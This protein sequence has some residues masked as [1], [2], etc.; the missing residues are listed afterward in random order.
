[1]S[2]V[3]S[4]YWINFV[5][6]AV[7]GKLAEADGIMRSFGA[8][9]RS[10]ADKLETVMPIDSRKPI[11]RG[12][13]LDPTKPYRTDPKLMFLSWSEDPL[14]ARWFASPDS[15]ISVPVAKRHPNYRGYMFALEAPRS[16]VLFHYS[17]VKPDVFAAF[18]LQH[19]LM[20]HEGQRQI[21][22]S[23]E[24][25]H[26]VITEPVIGLTPVPVEPVTREID[27]R[28]APSWFD[29]SEFAL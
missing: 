18:A 26:E 4:N 15:V 22:W 9:V 11:Y 25:Q 12:V 23:L 5:L 20:R 2:D 7:Y 19:P 14:V 6:H 27:R 17:W 10:F 24:T 28:L 1:M 16:R 8:R 13:L 21:R 29:E 3:D